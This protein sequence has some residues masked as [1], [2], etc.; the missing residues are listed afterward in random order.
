MSQNCAPVPC[1]PD[2]N[3]GICREGRAQAPSG[4]LMRVWF[5]LQKSRLM[6]SLLSLFPFP[7]SLREGSPEVNGFSLR[8]TARSPPVPRVYLF[9]LLCVP[10]SDFLYKLC[11]CVASALLPV[12]A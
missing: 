5:R 4:A 2:S 1:P 3:R 12:F 9:C 7:S 8:S 11:I 10:V 6:R